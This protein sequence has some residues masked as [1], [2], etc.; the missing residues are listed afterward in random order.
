MDGDS[1]VVGP[2]GAWSEVF[3]GAG[4]PGRSSVHPFSA[5]HF[6][7]PP[8]SGQSYILRSHTVITPS[9]HSLLPI[10]VVDS[11]QKNKPQEAP[12]SY[13]RNHI[14]PPAKQRR[15]TS[16]AQQQIHHQRACCDH[17]CTD[18]CSERESPTRPRSSPFRLDPQ[19]SP[20]GALRAC[21]CT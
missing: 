19:A 21:A 5:S 20:E 2:S 17:Q 13:H 18:C 4:L 9:L 3:E 12:T 11:L 16:T 14:S 1:N 7:R 15:I 6:R 8:S 10:Q